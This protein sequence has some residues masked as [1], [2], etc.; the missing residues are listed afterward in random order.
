MGYN[1]R[2]KVARELKLSVPCTF[3]I[4]ISCKI[5]LTLVVIRN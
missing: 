3:L 1:V 5:R 2:V 4:S